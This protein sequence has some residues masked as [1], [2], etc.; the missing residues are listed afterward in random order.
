MTL[1][2]ETVVGV[3]EGALGDGG[4]PQ[5]LELT[6]PPGRRGVRGQDEDVCSGDEE[7]DPVEVKTMM[8]R[9]QWK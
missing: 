3:E 8:K 9:P 4:G 7:E 6:V 1:R 5:H 2:L